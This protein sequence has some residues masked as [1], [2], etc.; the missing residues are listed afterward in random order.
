[1]EIAKEGVDDFA[2]AITTDERAAVTDPGG[3]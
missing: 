1:M 3:K 2:D